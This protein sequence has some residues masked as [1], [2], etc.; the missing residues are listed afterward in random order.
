MALR[1]LGLFQLNTNPGAQEID[2]GTPTNP[3][4]EIFASS[5]SATTIYG[6]GSNLTIDGLDSLVERVSTE[7]STRSSADTSLATKISTDVAQAI[8]DLVAGAPSAL[9]TL[10][11]IAARIGDGTISEANIIAEVNAVGARVTAEEAARL[12][13][14]GSLATVIGQL[15]TGLSTQLASEIA[16]TDGD[17]S[18]F[19]NLVSNDVA[20]PST[21]ATLVFN[22]ESSYA[23]TSKLETLVSNESSATALNVASDV[24][25]DASESVVS[26]IVDTS[27]PINVANELSAF[28]L[29]VASP[30]IAVSIEPTSETKELFKPLIAVAL[31]SSS[32]DN[33]S[34]TEDTS[35]STPEILVSTEVISALTSPVISF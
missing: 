16:S 20:S 5:I 31:A 34:S 30:A 8:S 29:A 15:S 24:K 18:S 33:L 21:E 12:S 17:V 19:V 22:D 3:L 4:D 28:N 14:D 35:P 10:V 23:L 1:Q 9:D 7:E 25:P 32:T 6:D 11:E 2:F 13:A 27:S 26:L